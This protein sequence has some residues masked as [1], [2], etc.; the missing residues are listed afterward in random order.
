[1]SPLEGCNFYGTLIATYEFN[2][3]GNDFVPWVLVQF[4]CEDSAQNGHDIVIN[5]TGTAMLPL[6]LGY[7]YVHQVHIYREAHK[8]RVNTLFT[9]DFTLKANE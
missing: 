7:E 4:Y 6:G 9:P 5:D 1:M 8:Y 3:D 2:C